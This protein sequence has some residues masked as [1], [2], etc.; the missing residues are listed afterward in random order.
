MFLSKKPDIEFVRKWFGYDPNTGRLIR[1][2]KLSDCLDDLVPLDK[3]IWF[4][5]NRFP[6][7]HIVWVVHYGKWPD[8]MIDH[9]DHDQLN[10]KI[11]NLREATQNQNQHN[12]QMRNPRGKGVALDT[13][14]YRTKPWMARIMVDSKSI[15]LGAYATSEE[16]A[17]AYKRAALKYH[18]EFACLE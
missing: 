1:K 18:G 6:Y 11:D 12:K 7:S 16:A 13:T 2:L 8:N 17:E 4:L 9:R 15:F 5:G 14:N 3:R 10:F